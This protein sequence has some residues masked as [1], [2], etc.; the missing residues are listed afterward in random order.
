MTLM[1]NILWFIVGG[2]LV[3]WILWGVLGC[4][5]EGAAGERRVILQ[6]LM[7]VVLKG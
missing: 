5:G 7:E 1:L 4:V 3:A 2:G 6:P